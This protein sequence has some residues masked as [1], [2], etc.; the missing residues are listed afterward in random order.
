MDNDDSDN[1]DNI[2][3][4]TNFINFNIHFCLLLDSLTLS[5]NFELLAYLPPSLSHHLLSFVSLRVSMLL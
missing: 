3:A 2:S 4:N 5:G 1:N